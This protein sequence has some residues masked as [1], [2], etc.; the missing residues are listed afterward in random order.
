MLRRGERILIALPQQKQRL[1]HGGNAKL[2][3][4]RANRGQRRVHVV[5]GGHVVEADDLQRS[6]GC[7]DGKQQQG[8]QLSGAPSPQVKN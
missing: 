6:R 2:F 7:G 5:H 1:T 8:E 4:I 3:K